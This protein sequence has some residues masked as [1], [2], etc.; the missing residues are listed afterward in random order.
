MQGEGN[1]YKQ[2]KTKYEISCIGS[3]GGLLGIGGV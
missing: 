1:K 3:V 2:E